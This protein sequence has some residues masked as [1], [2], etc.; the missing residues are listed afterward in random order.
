[1]YNANTK[2]SISAKKESVKQLTTY[3]KIYEFNKRKVNRYSL[4]IDTMLKLAH[5][6]LINIK[7]SKIKNPTNRWIWTLKMMSEFTMPESRS[8]VQNQEL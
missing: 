6:L 1:M 3:S 7:L 8:L 5:P 2:D 4:S